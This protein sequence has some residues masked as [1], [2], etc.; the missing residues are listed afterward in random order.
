[1]KVLRPFQ[2][3]PKSAFKPIATSARDLFPVG[4]EVCIAPEFLSYLNREPEG[5]TYKVEG[6]SRD[7]RCIIIRPLTEGVA[8]HTK[9]MWTG[10]FTQA[11]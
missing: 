2:L 4:M 6:H 11:E 10:F 5:K 7:G 3:P 1:M 8:S 9:T